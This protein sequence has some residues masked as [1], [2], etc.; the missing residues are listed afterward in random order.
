MKKVIITILALALTIGATAQKCLTQTLKEERK[1]IHFNTHLNI[2]TAEYTYSKWVENDPD[3]LVFSLTELDRG[4]SRSLALQEKIQFD[5][6]KTIC[7]ETGIGIEINRYVYTG[8]PSFI[9]SYKFYTSYVQVPVLFTLQTDTRYWRV[10]LGATFSHNLMNR[11][12]YSLASNASDS[13]T[14]GT[15]YDAENN[16]QKNKLELSARL[17]YRAIGLFA[18]YGLTK[19]NKESVNSKY[20]GKTNLTPFSV[21]MSINL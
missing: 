17:S 5:V 1:V 20:H 7:I 18:N 14:L 3:D 13:Y 10:S 4:L 11:I 8:M 21:G 6:T 2:G 16:M 15:V 19:I 12:E 9:E